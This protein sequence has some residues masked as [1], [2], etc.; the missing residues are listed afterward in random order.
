MQNK[1]NNGKMQNKFFFIKINN[2]RDTIF[3]NIFYKK[4]FFFY[5]FFG[6]DH[7]LKMEDKSVM[8][9]LKVN[10][11]CR[12]VYFGTS[13]QTCEEILW[14]F[15]FFMKSSLFFLFE[16]VLLIW[17]SLVKGNQPFFYGENYVL[18]VDGFPN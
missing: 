15:F 13:S 4:S 3:V 2:F 18:G 11:N 7:N 6:F 8:F 16:V 5:D 10:P 12:L 17:T 14:I 1:Q 9:V